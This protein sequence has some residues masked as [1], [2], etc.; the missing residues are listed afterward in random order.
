MKSRLAGL[1][2]I[3]H[4]ILAIPAERS[5]NWT[6]YVRICGNPLRLDRV[7]QIV[8]DA[9]AT[10][11]SGI[12]T[13]NDITGRYDSFLEPAGKLQAIRAVAEKAHAAG[14]HAFVYIA[15]LECITSG[16]D[17]KT[18]TFMK[19]HPDWVQR[20]IT[21][22]PAVFGGGS[23]FWI[24]KGD[25]DVWI[26]P[27]APEWRRIYMERVRQIAST[28]IDGVYVDIPYWMTHFDGWEDT[29]AS[30]DDYTVAAFRHET[31]LDAKKDI[32]LGDYR[33]PGFRR[34]VDFRIASLTA[35]MR[36]IDANIK[37][38]NPHCMTIAEIYPGI[39]EEAVRVGADVYE[40]YGV[41]NA[42]AHEYNFASGGGTAAAKTPLDWLGHLAG[43]QSFRAF[44]QGKPS[45][46]LTYSWDGEKNVDKREAMAN[47]FAFQLMWSANLWDARGHVMSGSNDLPTRTRVFAWVRQHENSF[48]A[49]RTP[50]N[51]AGVY[52]SPRTR[53]YFA[54]EFTDSYKGTL[55]LLLQSH[56]ESQVVTPATLK[57]FRGPV[58]ILPDAKCLSSAEVEAIR[59]L[60]TAGTC[61]VAT[62]ETGQ[63]DETG[64]RRSANPIHALL[65]L[66]NAAQKETGAGR[67]KFIYDPVCPGRAYWRLLAEE[68]DRAAA[69]GNAAGTRFEQVRNQFAGELVRIAGYQPAVRV[70]ASPFVAAQITQVAGKP[71][72]YLSNF[73]G[74]RSKQNATPAPERNV[75]L[76]FPAKGGARIR[77]LPFLGEVVDVQADFENGFATCRIPELSRAAVVWVE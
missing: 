19:D 6:H 66:K 26:T 52:F 11:V 30:F 22:E 68:F 27:Y 51:P 70:S 59:S 40:I 3:L 10:N 53:N 49:P 38:V 77:M 37:S 18:H 50:I 48:Y 69:T 12:E 58:L 57:S 32:R 65:A 63:F 9:L 7:D 72:V 36:E 55:A 67:P 23:A 74:L 14:N 13:D 34:W 15:G 43:I 31:N 1:L 21:G 39:E 60:A 24:A 56:I 33:D 61:I 25:E 8:A 20:K 42:V 54:S 62:G 73:A 64:S 71:H 47:M 16:A 76:A 45:W 28:G 5:Q 2:C 4:T 17:T 41:V 75:T 35:F 44:G 46:M 29:W